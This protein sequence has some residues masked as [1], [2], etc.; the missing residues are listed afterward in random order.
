MESSRNS[1]SVRSG[2][3]ARAAAKA[4]SEAVAWMRLSQMPPA[5]VP[6]SEASCSTMAMRAM[7]SVRS[8]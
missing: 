7:F 2:D 6:S 3:S 8:T 4:S 5:P 1:E